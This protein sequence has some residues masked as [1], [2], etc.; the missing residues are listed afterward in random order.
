MKKINIFAEL[1]SYMIMTAGLFLFAFSWTKFVIP[2]E[3]AG[4]GVVGMSSVIFYA[5]GFP[6]S[7][8]YLFI[9]VVLLIVGSIILGRGCFSCRQR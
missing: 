2:Q 8:S 6:V 9:N 3:I 4:G 7:Y 5:T 1:R